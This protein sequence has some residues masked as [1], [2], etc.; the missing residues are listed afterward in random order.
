M[1]SWIAKRFC[2]TKGQGFNGMGKGIAIVSF[3]HSKAT[4]SKKKNTIT[5][6]WDESGNWCETSEGIAAIAISYFESLY[7]SSH[8]SRIS[9]VTNTIL[10]RVTNEMIK[11]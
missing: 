11:T 7:T 3:F 4:Q 2:G 10:A 8:S 9:E 5:R 1:I 6:L